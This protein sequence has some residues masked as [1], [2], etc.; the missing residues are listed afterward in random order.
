[1]ISLFG[2]WYSPVQ[3]ERMTW[4]SI[5]AILLTFISL[6]VSL[7]HDKNRT[8]FQNSRNKRLCYNPWTHAKTRESSSINVRNLRLSIKIIQ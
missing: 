6:S 1:M 3:V 4:H 5:D 2:Q 7:C 8:A